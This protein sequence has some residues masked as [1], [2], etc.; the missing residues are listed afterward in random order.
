MNIVIGITLECSDK[1]VSQN[2]KNY[3]Q[4]K[5]EFSIR[6]KDFKKIKDNKAVINELKLSVKDS[7][8]REKASAILDSFFR[9]NYSPKRLLTILEINRVFE[10]KNYRAVSLKDIDSS[11]ALFIN[12]IKELEEFKK[13]FKVKVHTTT[14]VDTTK[15]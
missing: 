12:D 1:I 6:K 14:K 2:T 7:L 8:T 9:S 13:K 5:K 11:K 3:N 15:N 10:G 4:L